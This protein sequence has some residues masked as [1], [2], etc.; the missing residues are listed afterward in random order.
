MKPIK[1]FA[2]ADEAAADLDGQISVMQTN[3]LQGLEIRGVDG[4]NIAD[5]TKTEAKIAKQKLDDAGL[6][7][8]SIGSPIGKISIEEDF[9][10]HL[11][12][13][14]HVLELAHILD[15]KHL[16]MFSFYLPQG[17]EV[18]L[19]RGQVLEQLHQM[20]QV[21]TDAGVLLCH[22]NE[23]GIYGDTAVRCLDLLTQIPSMAG[24]FDPANFVQC[25]EDTLKAW[26]LLAPYT[27]YLHIKDAMADGAVVPAGKGVGNI[28]T[29]AKQ[30]LDS[31]K[32]AITME[33]HLTVFDGLAGLEQ[34]ED[35]S[36]VG[37]VYQYASAKQ[38]FD[39]A[40][41]SFRALL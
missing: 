14:R 34:P 32:T 12:R 6:I 18:E 41:E 21:A 7:T 1:L 37:R 30:Y 25:G 9:A 40:C 11:D 36:V 27:H 13:L 15:C 28:Q 33:P 39:V 17:K 2:F 24:V 35:S 22:E 3:N 5:L 19:Y 16:R 29:I 31:G 23:K 20:A 26:E 8:W 4:K 38:A 10:T